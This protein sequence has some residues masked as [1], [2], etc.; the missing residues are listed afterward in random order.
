M[1]EKFATAKAWTNGDM[2]GYLAMLEKFWTPVKDKD[3]NHKDFFA[4]IEKIK[5]EWTLEKRRP[6]V[7]PW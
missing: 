6:W 5:K 4:N 2:D 7:A 3:Q 1:D